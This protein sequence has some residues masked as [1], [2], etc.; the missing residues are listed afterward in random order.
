MIIRLKEILPA[1]VKMIDTPQRPT[2]SLGFR[3]LDQYYKVVLGATTYI[4]GQPS[5]GKSEWL[6]EMQI[7]LSELYGFKHLIFTP[8]T[9]TVEEIYMEYLCKYQK[10][11]FREKAFNRIT[12]VKIYEAGDFINEYFYVYEAQ[13]K[14]PSPTSFMEDVAKIVQDEKIHTVSIDPWNEMAHNFSEFGEGGRQDTY[15]EYVLGSIRRFARKHHIHFFLVAHPRTLQKNKEGR[16][17]PPTAFELSGGAPWY[18]KAESI[19]CVHRPHEFSDSYHERTYVDIIVQK[20]K[21][22]GVGKKGIFE[23]DFDWL[24]TGRYL[25]RVS[26]DDYV[27]SSEEQYYHPDERIEPLTDKAP[28]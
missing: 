2:Y 22:K 27:F 19:L 3:Q 24:R 28:F 18:A 23:A 7:R 25:S 12:D 5:H 14:T 26:D 10:M 17:D 20:A 1:V 16:Y 15:L 4:C 9:G 13:E 8:E 11:L 6:F 21:P